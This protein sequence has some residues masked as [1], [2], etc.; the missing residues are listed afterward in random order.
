MKQEIAKITA[1]TTAQLIGKA[2]SAATTVITTAIIARKFGGEQFGDFFLMTGFATYFYLLTD[3]GIN[4]VATREISK[5][6]GAA[7][8][9][10][11]VSKFFNNL[12][13]LRLLESLILVLILSAVL[14]FI[15]FRLK[16]VSLIRWGI[17][18][19]LFTIFSQAVYNS[20]TVVFQSS[21]SYHKLVVASVVGNLAFLALVFWLVFTG[22]D[23]LS[24]VAANTLGT[25]IVS[26]V[27]AYMVYRNLGRIGLEFDFGLWRRLAA[28]AFPLGIGIFLTVVVAKADQFLLSILKLSPSLGLTN[29]LA[30]GN[31][32]I[33]YKIFE[34]ILVFP[35]FF[36]NAAFP[37]LVRNRETDAAE[38]K[39]L[40]WSS[41]YFMLIFSILVT[42]AGYALAP[43]VINVIGGSSFSLAPQ[44]LRVLL[45]SLPLFF[46]SS[47]FLFQM[48]AQNQQ[49]IVPFIYLAAAVFNVVLNLIFIPDYG[50]MASAWITG[51]T[52]LLILILVGYFSLK[53]LRE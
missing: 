48:I 29:D 41:F 42:A 5:D 10:S 1:N 50:F 27:A 2:F 32:G 33:A 19:G 8:D 31:Y 18:I 43:W 17:I 53:G 35:T 26:G 47:L 34:N 52:E 37:L 44:A 36:V 20:A 11:K 46:T 51:A 12:L 6:G 9:G 28:A 30:L 3:F 7:L 14:P 39:K 49:K 38:H 23:V 15:P 22:R 16:E 4:A 25:F 21:L 45:L 24:L 40:F 13:T